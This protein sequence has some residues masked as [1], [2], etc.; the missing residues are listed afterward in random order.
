MAKIFRAR[1]D[2]AVCGAIAKATL[3]MRLENLTKKAQVR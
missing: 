3:R 2:S 1:L